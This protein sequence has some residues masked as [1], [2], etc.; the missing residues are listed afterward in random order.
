M[1]AAGLITLATVAAF[2]NS[3]AGPFV[4]DDIPSIVKNPT[5]RQL[6]PLWPTLCPPRDG[7]TVT[8][9]PLLNLSLAINY[10]VS[11]QRV[12]SYH[13]ANLGIHV[14]AALL[15]F[16]ILRRSFLLPTMR[17]RWGT[18]ALP[19]A[20]VVALL[21]AI[22]PLQTESVTY[23]VQRAESLVGL[24][25]FLTLYCFVRARKGTVPFS[26]RR[27]SGQS[28]RCSGMP[29]RCWP[30]CWAWPARR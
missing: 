22:H 25:Y 7:E 12:W 27:K 18:A 4:F 6:W 16:G 30:A 21:W 28:P 14:F 20:L 5:I 10:A 29:G 23:I 17:D 2:S 11:G 26:L 9:R 15:L 13:A 19:L 8:G 3:F 1:L 24:F